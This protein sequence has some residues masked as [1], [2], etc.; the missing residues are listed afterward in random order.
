MTELGP[1]LEREGARVEL[2][3]GARERF[4]HRLRR[5]QRVRKAGVYLV[6]CT[7]GLLGV[8]SAVVA[9]NGRTGMAPLGSPSPS[10]VRSA[11]VLP[12]ATYWTAPLAR[13]VLVATLRANGFGTKTEMQNFFHDLGAFSHSVRF[14][15]QVGSDGIWDQVERRDGGPVEIGW[16]GSYRATAPGEITAFGYGCTIRYGIERIASRVSIHVLSDEGP[17]YKGLCGPR[18]LV[19]QTVIFGSAS[20]TRQP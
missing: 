11:D 4:E 1:Q 16:S 3:P 10:T 8:G 9:L 15:I 5:R 2:A 19:A 12:P 14:G 6:A 20:F 7:V 18:D 17:T 13:P